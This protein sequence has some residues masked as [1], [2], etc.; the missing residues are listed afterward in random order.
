MSATAAK[1]KFPYPH[2]TCAEWM[3]PP[4]TG[5]PFYGAWQLGLF[6]HV[7]NTGGA[8]SRFAG[9]FPCRTRAENG[10]VLWQVQMG[11]NRMLLVA[12]LKPAELKPLPVD[13]ELAG[14]VRRI[15]P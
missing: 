14:Y 4:P 9:W 7:R 15:I 3:K 6:P 2:R 11:A 8:L 13:H 10:H 12:S 1:G 5:A